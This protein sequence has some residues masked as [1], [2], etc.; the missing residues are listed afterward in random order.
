VIPAEFRSLRKKLRPESPE[1]AIPREAAGFDALTNVFMTGGALNA[2]QRGF[3]VTSNVE[4]MCRLTGLNPRDVVCFLASRVM[5]DAVARQALFGPALCR[6]IIEEIL[7]L[8]G[9]QWWSE[10]RLYA[11]GEHRPYSHTDLSRCLSEVEVLAKNESLLGIAI[12]QWLH[13]KLPAWQ[14]RIFLKCG[15]IGRTSQG[16][17]LYFHQWATLE[18]GIGETQRVAFR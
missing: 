16:E 14:D 11:P 1:G 4:G 5:D 12:D 8:L 9:H 15:P 17:R 6:K 13:R 18:S 7:R 10:P 2:R 3:P